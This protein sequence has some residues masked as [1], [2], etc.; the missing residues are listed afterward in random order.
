MA[1]LETLYSGGM[2]T[3]ESIIPL[4]TATLALFLRPKDATPAGD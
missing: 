2:L 3:S 1:S 4:L